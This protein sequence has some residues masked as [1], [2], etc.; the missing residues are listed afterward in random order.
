MTLAANLQ[1]FS[2]TQRAVGRGSARKRLRLPAA[3]RRS[4]GEQLVVDVLRSLRHRRPI[5]AG[6]RPGITL[7]QYLTLRAWPAL[8]TGRELA[9]IADDW[10]A[11]PRSLRRAY[12]FGVQSYDRKIFAARNAVLHLVREGRR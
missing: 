8:P 11:S 9:E 10:G 2:A 7:Q 3:E 12:R 6:R 1:G 4:V 5:E